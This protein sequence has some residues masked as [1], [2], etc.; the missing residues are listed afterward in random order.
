[1]A[2]KG[3]LSADELTEAQYALQT[4]GGEVVQDKAFALPEAGGQRQLLVIDKRRQTPK[5]YPRRAGLPNKQPLV[6]PVQP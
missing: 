5:R 1:M 2:L 3:P 4:L 6:A